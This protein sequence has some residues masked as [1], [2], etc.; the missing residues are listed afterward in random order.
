LLQGDEKSN[1]FI[2]SFT[3]KTSDNTNAITY[4]AF[5]YPF[6]YTDLQNYLKKIDTKMLKRIGKLADDIYYHK[7]CAIK[8]LEGRRLDILTISSYYNILP[9]R[10]IKIKGLYPFKHD[11]RAYKFQDKKV[12]VI[13]IYYK[14]IIK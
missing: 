3:Y 12:I 2:L 13:D 10:E 7:E 8:S 5:T 9:E 1:E 4:F 11:K 14:I 6:S